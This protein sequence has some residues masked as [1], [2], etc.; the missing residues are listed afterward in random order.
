MA[1][2]PNKVQK[3]HS[4]LEWVKGR[5]G[6]TAYYRIYADT[7]SGRPPE[8]IFPHGLAGSN[9]TAK[10]EINQLFTEGVTFVTPKPERL[11]E[12]IL[13]IATNLGDL[14][15]DSFPRFRYYSRCR[16][17][18]GPALYWDRDGRARRQPLRARL[19][20]V[21]EGEQGGISES[22]NWHGG[23][24]FPILPPRLAGLRRGK[25]TSD[26]TSAFPCSPPMSG[27]PRPTGPG[28]A[29]VRRRSLASMTV[30]LMRC[31]TTA[32]SATNARTAATCSPTRH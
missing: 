18:D 3:E 4:R 13:K 22:V 11:V 28:T 29:R 27:S 12:H 6:W 31:S 25:A 20:K 15:L 26:R 1:L 5:S 32:S 10:S 9:R 23:G 17:Q 24:G 8:T 2:G 21:I 16:A 14:V 19:Q 30:G 7:D